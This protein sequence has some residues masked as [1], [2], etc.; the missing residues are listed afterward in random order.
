MVHNR[1]PIL[2]IS[3]WHLLTWVHLF[4]FLNES[5]CHEHPPYTHFVAWFLN[6]DKTIWG[7]LLHLLADESLR[8][9]LSLF[10]GSLLSETG[11]LAVQSEQHILLLVDILL[12][13]DSAKIRC[14]GGKAGQFSRE[15]LVYNSSKYSIRRDALLLVL[16]CLH[17]GI[18]FI[19]NNYSKLYSKK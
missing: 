13:L 17:T 6:G 1:I 7:D 16:T 15:G 5:L 19:N 8:H 14:L 9:T 10:Q 12:A 4:H 11:S 2:S 3:V 18:H